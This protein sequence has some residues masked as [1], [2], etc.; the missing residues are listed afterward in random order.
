MSNNEIKKS[1]K[2]EKIEMIVISII[3]IAA[4]ILSGLTR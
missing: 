4:F 1:M 2:K 3:A